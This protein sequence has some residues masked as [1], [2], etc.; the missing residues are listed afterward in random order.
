MPVLSLGNQYIVDFIDKETGKLNKGPLDLVICD[1]H[2]GG[3]GLLQLKHTFNRDVLYRTY[4]YR[5][6]TSTTMVRALS[7]VVES[8]KK[9]VPLKKGDIV[10]DIGS[11]DGTLLE[12]YDNAGIIKIGFEPS[13]LC[14]YS[15]VKDSII[16]NDYFSYKNF[17]KQLEGKKAKIITSIA[18]FYDLNDP[19]SFV[20]DIVKLLEKDGIWIIQM[21][22]LGLMIKNCTFD[23]ISHEHLEYYSLLSLER[24]LN[25][26]GLEVLDVELNDVNGG[27]FRIYVKHRDGTVKSFPGAKGRV[28]KLRLAERRA[29]LDKLNAYSNFAKRIETIKG[30]T[31]NLLNKL[32]KAKKKIFIYG[33]S[34]RGLVVLQYFGITSKLIDAAVDKN[35]DKQGKYIV[36][37]GIPIMSIEKYRNINPDYLFV[38]PYQFLDEIAKQEGE[39]LEKGGK[40]IVPLPNLRIIDKKYLTKR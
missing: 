38:L 12:K 22:Y 40:L 15:N 30:R 29:G 32:I 11:N 35:P 6:A 7:D 21:N 10:I 2:Y 23:N 9:L 18:M 3:C 17:P 26:N 33:A 5:S 36:G 13:N 19:N 39:F 14:K 25:R 20:G 37:T 4:W 16:I 24:L 8:V 34:T 31:L 1:T 28:T 27:S